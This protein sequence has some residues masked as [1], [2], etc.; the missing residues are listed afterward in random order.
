MGDIVLKHLN[1]EEIKVLKKIK[2]SGVYRD[3]HTSDYLRHERYRVHESVL[4]KVLKQYLL[5]K[6]WG[7]SFKSKYFRNHVFSD[8]PLSGGEVRAAISYGNRMGLLLVVNGKT[9]N[10]GYKI[11]GVD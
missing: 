11:K 10:R 1:D 8:C 2:A 9:G 4:F 7:N 3:R 5:F 6:D